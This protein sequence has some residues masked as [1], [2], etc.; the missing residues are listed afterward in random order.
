MKWE[1]AVNKIVIE[2]RIKTEPTKRKYGQRM[3]KIWYE[4]GLFP[5]TKQQIKQ[6][7]YGQTSGLQTQK[8]KE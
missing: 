5:V 6:G 7:R 1:E 3:K 4:I 8:F 2:C